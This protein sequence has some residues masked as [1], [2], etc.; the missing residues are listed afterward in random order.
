M[1]SIF[2]VM[3]SCACT[4]KLLPERAPSRQT[5]FLSNNIL[6]NMKPVSA[7][8]S[9]FFAASPSCSPSSFASPSCTREPRSRP[10][11]HTVLP[12]PAVYLPQSHNP[13]ASTSAIATPKNFIDLHAAIFQIQRIE[14]ISALPQTPVTQVTTLAKS[15]TPSTIF[16][17]FVANPP[18]RA[19]FFRIFFVLVF[20]FLW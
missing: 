15:V 4:K 6:L 18:K 14:P 12:H 5:D 3:P 16:P 17:P 13:L 10:P 2:T 11:A 1:T 9:G 20:H 19:A 7:G 8:R